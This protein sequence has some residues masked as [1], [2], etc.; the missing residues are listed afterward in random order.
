MDSLR[1]LD[2]NDFFSASRELIVT[3]APGRLDVMGGNADYS[4]SLVLQLP[5]ADATH[6]ALQTV[7]SNRIRIL[8]LGSNTNARFAELD[9]A[10]L[11]SSNLQPIEYDEAR[12]KFSNSDNHWVAYTFGIFLVLMCETNFVFPH[13]VD[14][15]IKSDVPEGKGVSSSAAIQVATMQALNVAYDLQIPALEIARLCQ[16]NEN[17]VAGAPCGI[18]DQMTSVCG[19][20]DRLL[21][22]LCQ[23]AKLQGTLALPSELELWGIDSGVRHSVGG[24]DYGTVRTA[25][26]MGYRIIAD[27][28]GRPVAQTE[29]QGKV[30]IDDGKWAG[31]LAN[32]TVDEFEATYS[33]KLPESMRGAEFLDRY[34]GISDHITSVNPEIDYPVR[35]ATRHPIYEHARV[36]QFA[37]ILKSWQSL[38]DGPRLGQLMFQSH[39]SYS[40]CG[41]GSEATD[42]IVELVRALKKDGLFGA[43]IT[44]GGSGGTVAVLGRRGSGAAIKQLQ[45]EFQQQTGYEPL[46]IS[47]SSP[48]A[49]IF[50]HMK[51]ELAS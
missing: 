18:M 49:S 20:A 45:L 27:I 24:A 40:D 16:K 36:R 31:Y 15:L 13:G 14:I 44:G 22:L 48:G 38:N 47:G 19:E 11:L 46:L 4:G 30:R 50:G 51:V 10:D 37:S 28:A 5:I 25:A 29:A 6:V 1:S 34:D 42:L 33:P 32:L 35:A 8:S 2:Q 39:Q 3:R 12:R 43:R 41:L 9:L 23:P 7:A 21:E 26:F 17:L